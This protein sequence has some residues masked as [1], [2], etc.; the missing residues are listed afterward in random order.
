MTKLFLTAF[1]TALTAVCAIAQDA[2]AFDVASLKPSEPAAGRIPRGSLQFTPGRVSGRNVTARR[3]IM[4]AYHLT[5]FQVFG[6]PAWLDSDR[7]DLEAKAPTPADKAQLRLMLQALLAERFKLTVQH[8][9]KEIPVYVMTV[10]KNGSKLL[11]WKPGE[12]APKI[13]ASTT[14]P[15]PN[16]GRMAGNMFDRTSM[17]DFAETLTSSLADDPRGGR[18]IID[19]TGLTGSYLIMLSWGVD[20]GMLNAAEDALGLRFEAQKKVM[21]TIAIDRIEKPDGN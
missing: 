14:S 5:Q 12:P 9:S 1:F 13:P 17:A 2:P 7:F 10:G 20:E 15:R 6:G 18:P 11:E 21:D 16:A 3:M 8:T 19:Q 4:A